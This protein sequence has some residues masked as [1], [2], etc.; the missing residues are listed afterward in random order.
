MT[1]LKL[2]LISIFAFLFTLNAS[3]KTYILKPNG[4]SFVRKQ[5]KDY[6]YGEY[7]NLFSPNNDK[8]RILLEFNKDEIVDLTN[9]KLLRKQN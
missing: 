9:G 3:A 7:D 6:N 4:D 8:S 1:N 5:G 2:V